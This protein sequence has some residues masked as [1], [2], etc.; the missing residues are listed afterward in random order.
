[1]PGQLARPGIR[2]T[3]GLGFRRLLAK[4]HSSDLKGVGMLWFAL[5]LP[6]RLNVVRASGSCL[7]DT[8]EPSMGVR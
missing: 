2:V 6:I 4:F 8:L 5:E 3:E 7:R 1:M